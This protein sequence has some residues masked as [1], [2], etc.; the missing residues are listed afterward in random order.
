M[1]DLDISRLS[2]E[3]AK[4]VMLRGA[5]SPSLQWFEHTNLGAKRTLD[6]IDDERLF[7]G[8]MVD[9]GMAAAVRSLLYIWN[10]WLG[11]CKMYAQAAPE[12]VRFHITAFCERMQGN[13]NPAKEYFQKAGEPPVY[14]DLHA[15]AL[16]IIGPGAA[17][18]LHRF[19]KVLEQIQTWEPYAFC[20]LYAQ[21]QSGQLGTSSV[22]AVTNL[23]N[24]EFELLFVRC[25]QAAT[26]I[27]FSKKPAKVVD[28]SQPGTAKKRKPVRPRTRSTSPQQQATRK[29]SSTKDER[30]KNAEADHSRPAPAAEAKLKVICPSC[31][32]KLTF[33]VSAR[34]AQFNCPDC[35]GKFLIPG[36]KTQKAAP[37]P[38]SAKPQSG[39][40]LF[41][42]GVRILCPKCRGMM[43]FPDS[44]RGER[45]NCPECGAS[46]I[47]PVKKRAATAS[48]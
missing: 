6:T 29:R 30:D 34:G 24:R 17:P 38:G 8:A 15:H 20:D 47:V 37:S 3:I 43:A 44:A 5:E 18:E 31:R 25:Y 23:Q 27:D 7:G 9:E 2:P 21:S 12:Q 16:K 46:F 4:I 33:P 45:K 13:I 19:R 40:E 28:K 1:L 10:G 32:S 41:V 11:E 26:G 39:S 35:R 22:V 42:Q 14:A 36:K 48:V